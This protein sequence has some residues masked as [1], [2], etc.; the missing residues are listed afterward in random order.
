MVN[1]A[2]LVLLVASAYG[3]SWFQASNSGSALDV[4]PADVKELG[5]PK[6][7]H[8]KNVDLKK[9]RYPYKYWLPKYVTGYLVVNLIPRFLKRFWDN[10]IFLILIVTGV[11][12]WQK[13]RMEN[14][15]RSRIWV[16]FVSKSM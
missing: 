5:C 11:A 3:H 2:L 8:P 14:F 10:G 12:I 7:E 16:K 1:V 6:I 4:N 9:V 13:P 15:L